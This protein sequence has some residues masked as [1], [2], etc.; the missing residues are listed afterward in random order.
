MKRVKPR[1]KQLQDPTFGARLKRHR[2]SQGLT[3]KH[4]ARIAGI[5]ETT[6]WNWE[7]GRVTPKLWRCGAIARALGVPVAALFSDE[8]VVADVVVSEA[9]VRAIRAGGRDACAD[10][11]QRLAVQLEPLIWAAVTAP[12]VDT[13]PGARPKRRRTRAEV[14]AGIADAKQHRDRK[15]Q[16]RRTIE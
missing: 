16:Q 12:A 6:Y 4:A 5:S 15:Q 7:S 11:A 13:R 14:L 8:L 3:V 10:V 9:T 2:L 1:E